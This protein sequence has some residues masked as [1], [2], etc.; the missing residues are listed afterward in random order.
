MELAGLA[1]AGSKGVE[2]QFGG[3]VEVGILPWMSGLASGGAQRWD[4]G[5]VDPR[6]GRIALGFK[7]VREAALTL[8][9]EPGVSLPL[10]SVGAPLGFVPL[11]TG[12][13]DPWLSATLIGGGAWLGVVSVEGRAPLYAGRDGV[14][15]GPFGRADLLGARRF[16]T[17]VPWL[18][19]STVGRTAGSNDTGAFWEISPVAGA[20]WGFADRWA[21]SL[22]LRV[23]VLGGAEYAV[24]G[25]LSVRAVIGKRA[26]GEH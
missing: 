19:V 25:G 26:S 22:T 23:P 21:G 15:Q 16:G 18:G 13:V 10:G 24:A 9:I 7:P 20:T 4:S 11:S 3:Q 6:D 17:V 12:S 8:S 2:A 5:A 1:G 14:V